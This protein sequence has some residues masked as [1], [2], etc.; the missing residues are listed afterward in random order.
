M[1][2]RIDGGNLSPQDFHEPEGPDVASTVAGTE[3]DKSID[4]PLAHIAN[5]SYGDNVAHD[6]HV[7]PAHVGQW[8]RLQTEGDH[9]VD[10]NGNRLNIDPRLLDEPVVSGFHAAVYSDGQG[11]YVVG[12]AG[13]D[14]LDVD[15]DDLTDVLQGIGVPTVQYKLAEHLAHQVQ[16]LAGNGHVAFTGHSLGGGLAAA[17]ALATGEN[18]VTFN[19]AGLSDAT[20]RDITHVDPNVVRE[21]Y[22]TNG[23]V[24]S[25]SVAGEPLTTATALGAPEQLGT[26]WNLPTD[27][28]PT[29]LG[30]LHNKYVEALEQG[31]P[32]RGIDYNDALES[33][34][35]DL[36]K[37]LDDFG[38]GAENVAD[39][40]S[41]VLA[42][43]ANGLVD[44]T[45]KAEEWVE[46]NFNPLDLL[47]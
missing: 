33:A 26:P 13:T 23:D 19:A 5:D 40:V 4:L 9:L 8:E 17:A 1:S 3:S 28:S 37:G 46:R 39:T 22:Q 45:G 27:I 16:D 25:Y 6:A 44:A 14:P 35:H 21:W 47:A 7:P 20:I 29:D 2:I 31:T 41:G 12:F 43:G 36:G 30:G 24:R 18:A 34:V 10:A 15:G 32:E 11:N 38:R 42:D